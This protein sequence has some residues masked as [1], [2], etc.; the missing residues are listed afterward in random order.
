MLEMKSTTTN[1][2][3]E[4]Q[5]TESGD[6]LYFVLSFFLFIFFCSS[7]FFSLQASTEEYKYIHLRFS[8]HFMFLLWTSF[9]FCFLKRTGMVL[10]VFY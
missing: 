8:V 3:F 4:P 6:A 9:F 5:K 7:C 10:Y 1:I 2:C